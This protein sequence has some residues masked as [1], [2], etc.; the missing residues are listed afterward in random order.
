MPAMT[1]ARTSYRPDHGV[2]LTRIEAAR[3]GHGISREVLAQAAGM[4]ERTYRRAISGGRAWPRQIEALRMA[5][6]SLAR[7]TRDG[8][9]M[10]P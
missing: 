2:A 9:G 3:R 6:R 8:G 1:K 10:F 5:M 4:S 7:E